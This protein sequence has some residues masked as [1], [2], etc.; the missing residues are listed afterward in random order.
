MKRYLHASK[1]I[2]LGKLKED[3]ERQKRI[4]NPIKD[5]INSEYGMDLISDIFERKIK[6]VSRVVVSCMNVDKFALAKYE[7]DGGT[8]PLT[9]LD[10]LRKVINVYSSPLFDNIIETMESKGFT[11]RNTQS[12]SD[13]YFVIN[14]DA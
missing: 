1:N 3:Q 5:S 11:Y 4:Y 12:L 7:E 2:D 8:L 14:F 6:G 10:K 9:S 13:G